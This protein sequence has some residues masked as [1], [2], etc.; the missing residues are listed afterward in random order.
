M[1]LLMIINNNS[2]LKN[3]KA[4]L[5]DAIDVFCANGYSVTTYITQKQNDAY[6][7]LMKNRI[8]YEVI[9]VFGGD[10]TL[11]EVSNAL[12]RKKNKT[13]IGYFPSGTMN[14]F[15][16]NFNLGN[17]FRQIAERICL[18]HVSYFDVGK[19]NDRYFN[20]VAAFGAMCNVPY[21]TDRKA[22][23]KFGTLAYIFEGVNNLDTIK[24]IN[25]K[26]TIDNKTRNMKLL[27]GLIF[28]GGRVAGR[29]LVSKSRSKL[30][31]GTFNI[32]LVDYVDSLFDL[33]DLF[34]I[35]TEP[36]KHLHKYKASE[37]TIEFEGDVAWTLDGEEGEFDKLV[38]IKNFN[39]ALSIRE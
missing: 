25:A 35:L 37:L 23:E 20:Y 32:L 9:C 24:P 31:D 30:D 11:N 17:D 2:G 7:Y 26:V 14:D 22:K 8:D 36:N 4:G 21:S 10:G 13:P 27:F 6:D 12:M 1:K 3:S 16:S 39:K 33:P 19:C 34:Q 18:N 29:Q 28:S 38:N 5:L 15:G